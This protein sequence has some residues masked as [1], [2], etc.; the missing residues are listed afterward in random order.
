MTREELELWAGCRGWGVSRDSKGVYR[1]ERTQGAWAM[2]CEL[3]YGSE[4]ARYRSQTKV[5]F[6][7]LAEAARAVNSIYE[8]LPF[9]P[10]TG[11]TIEYVRLEEHPGDDVL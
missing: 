9:N 6:M 10:T 4:G 2:R 8:D 3:L 5:G 11:E 7:A 1:D